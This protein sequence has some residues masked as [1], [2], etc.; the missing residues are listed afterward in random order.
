MKPLVKLVVKFGLALGVLFAL[1]CAHNLL[2]FGWAWPIFIIER[3]DHPIPVKGWDEQGLI[4]ADGQKVMPK[5][6]KSLPKD[7]PG[8]KALTMRGVD[9]EPDGRVFGLVE[10]FHGCGNDPIR[11]EYRRV[12]FGLALTYLGQGESQVPVA[13]DD[14]RPRFGNEI[15]EEVW[16]VAD[17][18]RF[19]KFA[20]GE[21]DPHWRDN[22]EMRQLI[23]DKEAANA[24]LR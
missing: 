23:R 8:M 20:R 1:F 15:F 5:G 18:H 19:L 6:M 4:L 12:D 13:K 2:M 3:L 22:E 17:A 16:R 14:Y 10:L 21:K 11:G 24:G 9:L 7:F